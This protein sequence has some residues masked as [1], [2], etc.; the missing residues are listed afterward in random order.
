[1]MVLPKSLVLSIVAGC[2][3][4]GVLALFW[5][6][7]AESQT[8]QSYVGYFAPVYSP[9]GQYVYFVERS[10]RVRLRKHRNRICFRCRPSMT[11]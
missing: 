11:Y 8:K 4:L 6:R 3:L 7:R 1:M 10:T 9:D 2:A 5:V